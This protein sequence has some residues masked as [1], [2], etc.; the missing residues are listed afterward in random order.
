MSLP[1][2]HGPSNEYADDAALVRAHRAGDDEAFEALFHRYYHPLVSW[3]EWRCHDH[4]RAEDIAQET[5]AAV[6]RYIATFDSSRP[7]WPWL[8]T[9]AGHLAGRE[10]RA[11]GPETPVERMPEATTCSDAFD[12]LDERALMTSAMSKLSRRHQT[13]LW[14]RYVEERR[15]PECASMM[16]IS[17][18]GFNQLVWRAR[19]LLRDELEAMG[20]GAGAIVASLSF[21]LR[22]L[23]RRMV[24]ARTRYEVALGASANLAA[25]AVTA[26]SALAI[27]PNLLAPAAAAHVP[28]AARTVTQAVTVQRRTAAP[29]P[30]ANRH[31]G[32][33][34]GS[35]A[36]HRAASSALTRGGGDITVDTRTSNSSS[37]VKVAKN[38]VRTG[39]QEQDDIVVQVGGLKVDTGGDVT[40]GNDRAVCSLP[41]VVSCT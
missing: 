6:V 38:P 18:N 31:R 3:I 12:S 4:A 41:V 16:N 15:G 8:R 5:F 36:S 37:H 17:P 20:R 10:T 7:I 23:S 22:R 21:G 29:S 19:R 26:A 1:A 27:V 40:G 34:P 2:M 9:I 11:V 33:L 14:L 24:F 25:F 35:R 13:A 32:A 28:V 30:S 39:T